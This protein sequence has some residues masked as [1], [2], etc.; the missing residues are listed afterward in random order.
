MILSESASIDIQAIMRITAS[1]A[2]DFVAGKE[3]GDYVNQGNTD[4]IE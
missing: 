3:G 4:S 1:S 2:P